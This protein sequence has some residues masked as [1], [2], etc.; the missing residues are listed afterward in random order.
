MPRGIGAEQVFERR[1]SLRKPAGIE[2]AGGAIVGGG[3]ILTGREV[4]RCIKLVERCVVETYDRASGE[5]C[6]LRKFEG[7]TRASQPKPYNIT[8]LKQMNIGRCI[9]SEAIFAGRQI[10]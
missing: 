4:E 5:G 7:A 3:G 2:E 8:G 6:N 1:D 10:E 9:T